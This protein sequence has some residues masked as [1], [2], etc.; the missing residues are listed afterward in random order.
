M[1]LY[2]SRYYYLLPQSMA[3]C[4]NDLSI[5][6]NVPFRPQNSYKIQAIGTKHWGGLL[7]SEPGFSIFGC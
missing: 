6:N 1:V 5:G 3:E 7:L 2:K 4:H